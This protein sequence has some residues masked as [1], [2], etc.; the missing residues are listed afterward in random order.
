PQWTRPD[1]TPSGMVW[2]TGAEEEMILVFSGGEP[3]FFD[4]YGRK[5]AAKPVGPGRYA[6]EVSGAPVFFAGARIDACKTA[7]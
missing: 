1:G 2:T 6:V 7:L 5:L 4:V 3:T